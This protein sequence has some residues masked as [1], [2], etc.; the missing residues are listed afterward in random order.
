M[1]IIGTG[2]ICPVG[3]SSEA[4]CAAL[5]AGIAAFKELAYWD[6]E[7]VPV[8]GAEVAGLSHLQF[9]PRLVELLTHALYDCMSKAPGLSWKDVPLLVSLA[10]PAG[11]GNDADLSSR[12]VKLV[13]SALGVVF[14]SDLSRVIAK[15]NVSGFEGLH[16]GHKLLQS[17]RIPGF[18]VC[19]VDSFINASAIHW[20][21]QNYRLKR[22]NHADGTI[23]GEGA[24][25]V[26]MQRDQSNGA[27]RIVGVG[28]GSE[29]A[30]L[31]SEEPLLGHG[32]ADA[33]RGALAEANWGFH[34]IDFR[35]SDV[36]GET[37][38][39]REHTLAEARL[40]TKVRIKPQPIWHASDCIGDTGA[41]AGLVQLVWASAA[42][43]KRYAPGPRA[44]CFTS[45]LSRERAVV[46]ISY[47]Q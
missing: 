21:D 42:M 34:D 28:S 18:I 20:L 8:I 15:G 45:S 41:V 2:M 19:G 7:N 37:Y 14:H 4:G 16:I 25:A 43:Q 10:D 5:R 33:A 27:A 46:A 24:A 32:L 12:I 30:P 29:S 47:N 36:T 17:S 44:L 23:P 9:A 22:E 31:L 3:L 26:Y 39:F 1:N 13:E 40:V 6:C 11:P 38:G 35:L